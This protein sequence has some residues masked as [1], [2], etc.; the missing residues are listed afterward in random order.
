MPLD[1]AAPGAAG[2]HRAKLIA[3]PGWPLAVP[4]FLLASSATFFLF[5][6]ILPLIHSLILRM[7]KEDPEEGG[8]SAVG[9][10]G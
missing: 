8:P 3:F 1:A 4:A 5:A 9:S 7:P 10:M 2:G 6:A